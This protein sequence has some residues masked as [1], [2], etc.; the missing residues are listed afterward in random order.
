[1]IFYS[2]HMVPIESYC[3]LQWHLT[4]YGSL[5]LYYRGI[6][7][8]GFSLPLLWYNRR[9]DGERKRRWLC[10]VDK[11]LQTEWHLQGAW[12]GSVLA[13]CNFH[14]RGAYTRLFKF[15]YPLW[16]LFYKR[17]WVRIGIRICEVERFKNFR[18][19]YVID[20]IFSELR[21]KIDW[22]HSMHVGWIS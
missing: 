17:I 3:F 10:F 9:A 2:G 21:L 5:D 13:L 4:S 1:M 8:W 14:L 15:C 6:R 18:L 19:I 16:K 12:I 11:Y 20:S 7:L 22:V